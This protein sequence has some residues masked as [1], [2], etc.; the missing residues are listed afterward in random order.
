MMKEK[1]KLLNDEQLRMI[2]E[3]GHQWLRFYACHRTKSDELNSLYMLARKALNK[4]LRNID[5]ERGDRRILRWNQKML[6]IMA[7]EDQRWKK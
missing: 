5:D 3:E 7:I 4:L 2:A 1:I 6:E